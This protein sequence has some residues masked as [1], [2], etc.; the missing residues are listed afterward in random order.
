MVIFLYLFSDGEYLDY[1]DVVEQPAYKINGYTFEPK[2]LA[3]ALS[4]YNKS[5]YTRLKSDSYFN[6]EVQGIKFITKPLFMTF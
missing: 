3:Q 2:Q 4:W 1:D 5:G 6:V